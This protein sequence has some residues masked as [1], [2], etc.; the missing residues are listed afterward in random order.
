MVAGDTLL[1][2]R[3]R[4]GSILGR[5]GMS[6]V[7]R[8]QDT[9]TGREVAIKV[10]APHLSAD[11]MF[12]RRLLAEARAVASLPHPHIVKVFDAGPA[13]PEGAEP[14]AAEDG[15][16]ALVMELVPGEG[17]NQR[18]A[19]GPL[20]LADAVDVIAQVADALAFAHAR[21]I[22]HR[23][24]KP[25]NILLVEPLEGQGRDQA[26]SQPGSPGAVT[27]VWAKLADF[28]IA[29]SVDAATSYTVTGFVMGS[30]PYIAPEVLQGEPGDARADIYSLGITLFEAL[31]GR[32]PFRATMA[33]QAL[34][35]RL[36]RDA[37]R[38]SAFR[39]DAPPWLDDLVAR[40]LERDPARRLATAAGLAGA[41]GQ[42]S[43]TTTTMTAPSPAALQA[44]N[45]TTIPQVAP[46]APAGGRWPGGRWAFPPRRWILS[47]AGLLTLLAAGAAIAPALDGAIAERA[48]PAGGVAVPAPATIVPTSTA[49]ATATTPVLVP[50]APTAVPP[51]APTTPAVP[52]TATP[53]APPRQASSSATPPPVSG[54]PVARI[55]QP[56]AV[57]RDQARATV[58]RLASQARERAN[59]LREQ[60][61]QADGKRGA[62]KKRDDD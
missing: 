55:P 39:P 15:A 30:A 29:R 57:T 53:A 14:G 46:S 36:T 56:G 21:G 49:R 61:R 27:T 45:A 5:G 8:G 33:A 13:S 32:L 41:L 38:V 37:P 50:T 47:G 24:V 48:A 4:Q 31:A 17:L 2:G 3:Y 58:E 54:P 11:P 26:G 62:I 28:G 59:D 12:R 9:R 60:L 1:W 20:P 7:Y 44:A 6:T 25:H 52:T 40:C 51:P 35:Q 19:R 42:A 43:A 34:A 16:V 22:V 23:D 10:L 18:I